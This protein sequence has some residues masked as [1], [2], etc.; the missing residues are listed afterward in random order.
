MLPAGFRYVE[1]SLTYDGLIRTTS[2]AADGSRVNAVL[3]PRAGISTV[4]VEATVPLDVGAA[5]RASATLTT[6]V[7]GEPLTV[8]TAG[9]DQ[10][11]AEAFE[12]NGQPALAT[13]LDRDTLYLTHVASAGDEDW[14]A[15]PVAQGEQLSLILSNLGADF[16]MA[17]FGP[18]PARLRGLPD[19]SLVPVADGGRS[20][21]AEGV[22]PAVQTLDDVDVVAP[23]GLGLFGL[24]ANRGT[25]DERIDTTPLAAGTYF[26]RVTGYQSATSR[27]PYALRAAVA[28]PQF[29]AACPAI[30]HGTPPSPL[31][32]L[33]TALPTGITTLFVV[34]R[35]RLA[36]IYATGASVLAALDA[37]TTA[38]NAPAPP[39]GTDP[40]GGE[41]A[42]VLDVSAIAN[43]RGANMSRDADPCN[44]ERSNAVV[45]AIGA[46]I[47]GVVTAHPTVSHVVLVGNDDQLPFARIRDAT[48]YSNERDYAVEVGDV[49]SPLTS[50]LALGFVLSDDPYGDARPI[51]VGTRELFV[52]ERAVGRLVETPAEIVKALE[53][54]VTFRGHLDPTTTALSTG[55]DFLDDGAQAVADAL[56]ANGLTATTTARRPLDGERPR[57]PPQRG[58]G[59]RLGERPFRPLPGTTC[60]TEPHRIA[61]HPLLT[62]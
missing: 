54:Y 62:R 30:N 45:S 5:G 19:G 29:A 36:T 32:P 11:V 57:R 61:G 48:V 23:A 52:P 35:A 4:V 47:D 40:F 20:L 12:P 56:R 28:R 60:R 33:N 53:N 59:H 46:A 21:L 3:E 25:T 17:L 7:A 41:V 6:T 58:P 9:T 16:D 8:T 34:D 10:V 44:P 42:G 38:V 55:Y 37:Y 31:P 49:S 15:I 27:Q 24:G 13:T 26:V 18:A 1:G 51:A 43:V 14:F 2:A 50:A 22:V 39:G